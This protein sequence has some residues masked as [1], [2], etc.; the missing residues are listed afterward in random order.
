[1]CI[2]DSVS[3][4]QWL[5]SGYLLATGIITPA[6]GFLG[7][8]FGYN[9]VFNVTTLLVLALS[10]LGTLS[11]CIEALIVVRLDVYKRQVPMLITG[12]ISQGCTL[13]ASI[14]DTK[15][16]PSSIKLT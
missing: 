10:L 7:D 13:P 4:V 6:A 12:A 11:W 15:P 8:R 9:R 1:M 2:R 14:K 3:T 16:T 5:S